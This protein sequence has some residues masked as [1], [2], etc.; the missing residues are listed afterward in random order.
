MKESQLLNQMAN[1]TRAGRDK[2]QVR[3]VSGGAGYA[4]AFGRWARRL[5]LAVFPLLVVIGVYYRPFLFDGAA[6][7][8]NLGD[9]QFG[10]YHVSRM[11]ELKGRWWELGQDELLGH[12][13]PTIFARQP[14]VY[15]GVDLFLLS[16]LTAR[17]LHPV[18]NYYL[19]TSL[20]LVVNGWIAAWSVL[21][22][23][24]SY[25]WAAV[26]IPLIILNVQFGGWRFPAHH[27]ELTIGWI[28][29]AVWA[30]YRYLDA[31]SLRRG[32]LLG[33]LAALVVQASFYFGFFLALMLGVWWLGCLA[34]GSLSRRHILPTVAACLTAA[35]VGGALTFPVWTMSRSNELAGEFFRRTRYE[36][37]YFGSELWEYVVPPWSKAMRQ[38]DCPFGQESWWGACPWEG[39]N[40]LGLVI[41][42][43]ILVYFVGRLR[44]WLLCEADPRFLDRTMG[45]A[46]GFIVLTLWGGPAVLIYE[47]I[48]WFRCYG[49]AGLLA[50]ALL[51]V[52]APVILHGWTKRWP[53]SPLRLAVFGGALALALYEGNG[54]CR[55]IRE[56]FQQR[57]AADPAWVSWLARQPSDTRVV[58][59]PLDFGIEHY[60][61]YY[62]PYYRLLHKHATLNGYEPQL[63]LPDLARHGATPEAMNPA[64]LRF[65]V[66]LGYNTLVFHQDYLQAHP[67]IQ[68]LAG[69]EREQV[70]GDW[71][72]YRVRGPLSDVLY[73]PGTRLDLTQAATMIYLGGTWHEPTAESRCTGGEAFFKFRLEAVQPLRFRM[74]A[75]TWGEQRIVL[76]LNGREVGTLHGKGEAPELFELDLPPEAL[77]DNN[78]LQLTLPDA[79]SP[80]S[81]GVG[82]DPRILGVGV[83]W[84]EF[85]PLS[86]KE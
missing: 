59:F 47:V 10:V 80:K 50:V 27:P 77:A 16:S 83:A 11:G 25:A 39:Y 48:P 43:A 13:Y 81:V 52:A 78:V 20:I 40:Y 12:P 28:L 32:L 26:A 15:V 24:G 19:L 7:L 55:Q 44:G 4:A 45:L 66:S 71:H 67:W 30:F 1:R 18:V 70:L 17:F 37:W 75:M 54:F 29:P 22:L 51:S 68:T 46:A 42:T 57:N 9:T 60:G 72:L 73:Q 85:E 69:L 63:F 14:Q 58:V 76:R 5:G 34:A 38:Y 41:L 84:V 8:P 79:K 6:V 53:W 64:G 31:P 23:T 2:N 33:F 21:R 74:Q 86:T 35:L 36:M 56:S 65:I 3:P 62:F 82:E 61:E 49:R